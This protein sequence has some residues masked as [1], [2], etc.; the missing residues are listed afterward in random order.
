MDAKLDQI[1]KRLTTIDTSINYVVKNVD[2]LIVKVETADRTIKD[3]IENER[4]IIIANTD[5]DVGELSTEIGYLTGKQIPLAEKPRNTIS[6]VIKEIRIITA[7]SENPLIKT[8][9]D[10]IKE[11]GT[12]KDSN[13]EP[14]GLYKYW[15]PPVSGSMQVY[16]GRPPEGGTGF[17][18]GH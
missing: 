12:A 13:D 17:V 1:L 11:I 14:T 7:P 9:P 18:L 2:I 5:Q 4:K 8:I 6:D 15:S 16:G 3:K 10:V